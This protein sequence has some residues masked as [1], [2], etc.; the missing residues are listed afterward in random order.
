MAG[1]SPSLLPIAHGH[2][3]WAGEQR[4]ALR[5]AGQLEE[6]RIRRLAMQR[7]EPTLSLA[8]SR[9]APVLGGRGAA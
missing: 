9:S 3:R 5:C 8:A 6:A 4:D 7:L 2:P 1:M